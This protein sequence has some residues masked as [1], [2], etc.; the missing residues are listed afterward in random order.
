MIFKKALALAAATLIVGGTLPSLAA[1]DNSGMQ[2]SATQDEWHFEITPYLWAPGIK[3]DF[4]VNDHRA[5]IDQDFSSIFK[6]VKFA[7]MGLAVAEYHNWLVWTQLDYMYLNTNKLED[8]PQRGEIRSKELF[9]TA[10]GGYRFPLW[11]EGQTL[12]V[13]VG[14]SGIHLDNTLELYNLGSWNRTHSPTDAVLVLRPS[15][16]LSS[17]W[18]FNPTLQYGAGDSKDTYQLQPQFQYNITDTLEARI[19]YRKMHYNIE[20]NSQ[21]RIGP[22]LHNDADIS[23]SGPF[24]GVGWMF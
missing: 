24:I 10:A 20:N 19:G 15:I 6:V 13:L 7:A 5:D 16:Q 17:R 22:A 4:T 9:W 18:R 21:P 3:G 12:D 23:L 8:A 2:V 11:M 1:A 14:A